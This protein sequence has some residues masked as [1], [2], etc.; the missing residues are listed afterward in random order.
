MYNIIF[1]YVEYNSWFF[2]ID[3]NHIQLELDPS[4]QK[5]KAKMSTPM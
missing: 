3:N 1:G 4:C 5:E 2:S